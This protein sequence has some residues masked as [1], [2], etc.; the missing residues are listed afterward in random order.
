LIPG[1]HLE[2]LAVDLF[3]QI[4]H[5]QVQ[6]QNEVLVFGSAITSYI[7]EVTF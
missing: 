4:M 1:L 5:L 6:W 2:K 3:D 7:F